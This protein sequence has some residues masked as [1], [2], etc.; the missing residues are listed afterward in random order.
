MHV[1]RISF[2]LNHIVFF[3]PKYVHQLKIYAFIRKTFIIV[4]LFDMHKIYVVINIMS[5]EI[6]HSHIGF[7]E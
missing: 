1:S 3:L 6:S 2:Y 5:H 7:I 4:S